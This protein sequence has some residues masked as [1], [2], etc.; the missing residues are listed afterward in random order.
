MA[1][2]NL[3]VEVRKSLKQTLKEVLK[4][5]AWS[6][7]KKEPTVNP[8]ALRRPAIATPC[9]PQLSQLSLFPDFGSSRF[10]V[11][12]HCTPP[13]ENRIRSPDLPRH[14]ARKI[15]QLSLLPVTRLSYFDLSQEYTKDTEVLDRDIRYESV[16]PRL[17]AGASQ[18][19]SLVS[20]CSEQSL[21]SNAS[22]LRVGRSDQQSS[23]GSQSTFT[24]YSPST[25]VPGLDKT[26]GTEDLRQSQDRTFSFSSSPSLIEPPTRETPKHTYCSSQ[27]WKSGDS[28]HS[29]KHFGSFCVLDTFAPGCPVTAASEDLRYVF[30]VGEQFFL[31]IRECNESWIDIVTGQKPDGSDVIHLVLFSPLMSPKTGASRFMLAAL[32]DITDFVHEVSRLP[33]LHSI[34]EDCAT[35]EDFAPAVSA[36]PKSVGSSRSYEL[37]ADELLR[38]C[39]LE[40]KPIPVRKSSHMPREWGPARKRDSWDVWLSLAQEAQTS[41]KERRRLKTLTEQRSGAGTSRSPSPTNTNTGTPAPSATVDEALDDFMS[42]LQ[43]LYSYSFLLARSPL[44]DQYYEICNVSPAIHADGDYVTGHLTHTCSEV[45]EG[46]SER[47]GAGVAFRTMV[48]WGSR[49]DR[50]RLY[51]VPLYGQRSVTWICFLV[52][53][54]MPILW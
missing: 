33:E 21:R 13:A 49:G 7:T 45:I 17:I 43:E 18:H 36:P 47:L 32:V 51:C 8:A 46:I 15:S 26:I 11:D 19:A 39:F 44:D 16:S 3:G 40:D 52:D 1:A 34:D 20:T 48:H 42:R 27:S 9:L 6:R 14:L 24:C 10:D 28:S 38:G 50:K 4:C 37:L 23:C 31:N 53:L 35:G 54:H 41:K 29:V 25:P 5:R 12:R 2:E 30:Q 22:T